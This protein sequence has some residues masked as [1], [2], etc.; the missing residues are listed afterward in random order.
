M[1]SPSPPAAR[2]RG[3]LVRGRRRRG[4]GFAAAARGSPASSSAPRGGPQ[5][6]SRGSRSHL[7][8]CQDR[9]RRRGVQL[10]C[11]EDGLGRPQRQ[12]LALVAGRVAASPGAVIF[13]IDGRRAAPETFSVIP[14]RVDLMDLLPANASV[15]VSA[16]V[17]RVALTH[18]EAIADVDC[19]AI[20]CS[21]D[22]GALVVPAPPAASRGGGREAAPH[23]ARLLRAQGAPRSPADL[24][25][26]GAPLPHDGGV[27]AAPSAGSKAPARW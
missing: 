4:G 24:A 22:S 5:A 14:A 25:R 18:P 16:G 12:R 17:G 7:P 19:G 2:V 27:G 8:R 21:I 6:G 20:H 1:S 3:R 9:F 10:G 23:P 13:T 26:V 15:D 11:A